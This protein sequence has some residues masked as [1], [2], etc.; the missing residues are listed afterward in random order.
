MSDF[1]FYSFSSWQR[2]FLLQAHHLDI[3]LKSSGNETSGGYKFGEMRE[4][5]HAANWTKSDVIGIWWRPEYLYQKFQG[6]DFELQAINL[7]NPN[8]ECVTNRIGADPLCGSD[9]FGSSD[10]TCDI[11]PTP[12][13]KV[14]STGLYKIVVDSEVSEAKQSPAYDVLKRF[15]VNTYEVE[16]IF[17]YWLSSS[18]VDKYGYDPRDAVC[19]W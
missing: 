8:T 14:F 13:N 16:K 1:L 9:D 10:W 19:R 11:P 6:T 17:E 15:T 5:W 2:F 12:L 18:N 4:I 3:G 7:P